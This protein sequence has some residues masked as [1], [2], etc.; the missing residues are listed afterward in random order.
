MIEC[1]LAVKTHHA[2]S[3]L[4]MRSNVLVV[5]LAAL[6]IVPAH[7][8]EKIR[9]R[10]RAEVGAV[11]RALSGRSGPQNVNWID[12]GRRL[13]FVVRGDS[14]EEIRALD[15]ATGRDTLLFTG[16]GLVFPGTS[17]AFAYRSFQWAR[18]S[19]HLVF[20]THF[21]PLYRNS[22]TADYFVYSLADRTLAPAARG[23]RTSELSPDGTLLGFERDGDMYVYDMA[24]QRET[25]LTSDAKDFVYNGHFDWVYEEEFGMAQAWDW[26]PDSRYIAFWQL[27]ET[28]EPVIQLSEYGAGGTP[29]GRSSGSRSLA[30]R[31]PR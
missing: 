2:F 21:R 18:D 30:T 7:A 17:E 25:R 12:G 31:T 8:Q 24:Q 13:S 20:Q 1:N 27:D 26:S 28:A 4:S 23:A 5:A 10:S 29:S 15:P 3:G 9:M 16:R 6:A 22:G 14:G 19:K 11:S